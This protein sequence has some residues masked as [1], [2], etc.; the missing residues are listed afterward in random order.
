MK[1]PITTQWTFISWYLNFFYYIT[2][3]DL[4]FTK[5]NVSVLLKIIQS[6]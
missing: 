3:I 5:K 4:S 6:E 2:I 1:V